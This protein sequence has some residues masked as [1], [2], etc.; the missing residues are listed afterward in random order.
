MTNKSQLVGITWMLT[1]CLL[2]ATM[3]VMVKEASKQFHTFEIVFFHNVAAFLLLLPWVYRQG[4]RSVIKTDKIYLHMWRAV[5]AAT[6]L[7]LYFYAFTII[8]LTQARAIALTG[9]LVSSVF[10]VIFLKEK[11]GWHRTIAL[12]VGFIGALVIVQPG[13][14]SFAFV[15]LFVIAAVF[16][17]STIEM[18]IKVL[19]RTESMTTQLFYLLGLMTLFSAPFAIYEWKTPETLYQWL[20]LISIG[21]IFLVNNYAVFNA[22]KYADVTTIVPFDFSGMIFTAII[23]YIAFGEVMT[24]ATAIGSLIIVISSVYIVKREAKKAKE[25]HAVPL[26]SEE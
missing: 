10:A 20:W 9:P 14:S 25:P 7:G 3:S 13:T 18:I 22:F 15:S 17:W 8:P 23:A 6:A 12:I 4:I 2:I 11:P 5:L 16:L 21:V 26:H 19:A 24:M 1:H